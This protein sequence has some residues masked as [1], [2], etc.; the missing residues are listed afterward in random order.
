M[1]NALL[2]GFYNLRDMLNEPIAAVQPEVVSTAIQATLDEHRRQ[3]DALI[4][5]FCER[6][7]KS[8]LRYRSPGVARNQP[9]DEIGLAFPTRRAGYYDVGFP[10]E[11][12][13]QAWGMDYETRIRTSIREL[14]DNMNTILMGDL[15]WIRDHI[16]AAM[17]DNTT[18]PFDDDIEGTIT[19]Q[20]LA[21]GDSVTYLIQ[22]G[23]EAGA[24]DTHYFAQAN[25]IDDGA[26]NPFP[27]IYTELMEHTEN[28][29]SVIVLVPSGLKA[30]IQALATFTEAAD[31]NIRLG[32]AVN[33]LIVTPGVRVP[34]RLFGYVDGCYVYEWPRM[35][36]GYMLAVT[37]DGNKPLMMREP[38]EAQLRGFRLHGERENF[39]WYEAQL[40]RYAGFGANNRVGALV[41]R[42]GNG[43]YAI[44]TGYTNPI[45]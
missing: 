33:E 41:Y 45:R 20:P 1:A 22:A 42:V 43:S 8:K 18:W 36:A 15:R 7:T 5:L 6:T 2:Y 30:S 17:L 14:N 27:A 13:G 21:N 37:S 44:P 32:T 38:V 11:R 12:S 31:P 34:G 29:G 35:P 28:A 24:T 9:I 39:P 19:V 40:R 10:L 25:A 16:L 23:A 3:T 26:D 4:G